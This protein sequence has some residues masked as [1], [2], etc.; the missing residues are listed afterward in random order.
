MRAKITKQTVDRL[1]ATDR[2]VLVWD[3]T[4][5][6]FGL[7]VTT[8][9]AKTYLV[10][11]RM[12][13][14]ATATKRL[15]IGRHG[16]PWTA[17]QARDRAAEILAEVRLGVDPVAAQKERIAQAFT[18]TELADRYVS[19]HLETK[20]RASTRQEA[21]RLVERLIKPQLG[22]KV[23]AALRRDDV[24]AFH[25]RLKE[26][27][28]QANQ[29]LAVLSKMLSLA[30]LWGYRLDGTNPC[31]R[32]ERYAETKRE[33]FLADAEVAE[34]G[35]VLA[36]FE[37]D[38]KEP[39]LVLDAVRLLLL[40]GCRLGEA[41]GL[42]WSD[43]DLAGGVL[44]LRET[45]TGARAHPIGAATVAFLEG[46]PRGDDD[47]IFPGRSDKAPLSRSTV[48]HAWVGI[49]KAAGFEDVRLHDLR[50]TVGTYAGQTGANAF[51]VRDKLGH[52]TLAMTGRYVN[53][54]QDPV[55][56]LSDKIEERITAALGAGAS[57]KTA[58]VVKLRARS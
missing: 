26:T 27:P 35:R 25:H 46:M 24:A 58:D 7:K 2:E 12:G 57:G 44:N 16:S 33:R 54:A 40:T 18:I 41:L 56:A 13:G 1:A 34:L 32:V 4:L 30:E 52:K 21:K 29:A 48:E 50:H 36:E 11:Y 20:N 42:R 55:R 43:V 19:D 5:K 10:Q 23:V 8:G 51:L 37:R 45:K 53:R 49:R 47:R 39:R 22:R 6:G 17:E 31:R 15:T 38:R 28:R 9:G 14:R 3:E